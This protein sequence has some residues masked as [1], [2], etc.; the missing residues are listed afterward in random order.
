MTVPIDP[1]RR[2]RTFATSFSTDIPFHF[3]RF[4]LG[5]LPHLWMVTAV[6]PERQPILAQHFKLGEATQLPTLG[7]PGGTTGSHPARTS[8]SCLRH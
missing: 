6:A 8:L 5:S 4:A 7:S 3:T 2:K 1:C